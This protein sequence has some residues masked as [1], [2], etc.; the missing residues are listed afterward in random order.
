LFGDAVYL[1]AK[2]PNMPVVV[3]ANPKGGAGKSTAALVLGTTLA[4]LGASVSVLDCDP[5]QPLTSWA[6]GQSKSKVKVK[7][8]HMESAL[9]TMIE[10]EA[11]EHQ[12][13]I[14]DLEGTASQRTTRAI[15][16]ANL[17]I[18]PLQPSAID[19]EQAGRAV[20]V[21][22]EEEEVLGRSIPAQVL[23]TRTSATVP[24]RQQREIIVSLKEARVPMFKTW[25]IERVAYKA[26]F[27]FK[28][29]LK[30]LEDE[31]VS[32]LP[33]AQKNAADFAE[34]VIEFFA[35]GREQRG[36]RRVA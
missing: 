18:I 5:N 3:F 31:T 2:E 7:A 6:S 21:V 13:V 10:R 4:T 23:L 27:R 14:V 16:R 20:A 1:A 22:R 8:A 25:L 32:G 35:S 33:E 15:S 28:K 11:K 19:A 26:L 30:E 29:D 36:A 24:S 12:F 17:V 34:E 9:H